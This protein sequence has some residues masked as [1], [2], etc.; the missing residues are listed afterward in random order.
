[1]SDYQLYSYNVVPSSYPVPST[2]YLL[3]PHPGGEPDSITVG[4]LLDKDFSETSIRR[5]YV[6]IS[7]R[8]E[9]GIDCYD[10]LL[11]QLS[12]LGQEGGG[13][14]KYAQCHYFCHFSLLNAFL[15]C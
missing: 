12:L 14:L 3:H 9:G 6:I 4:S 10:L 2:L 1:M 7:S 8:R 13:E 15:S 11:F 5:E